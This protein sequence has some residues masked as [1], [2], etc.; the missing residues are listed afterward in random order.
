M[1]RGK[2]SKSK[3]GAQPKKKTGHPVLRWIGY[4][5]FGVVYLY[6]STS[7]WIFQGPFPA[8][9][10]YLI[11]SL[12]ATRHGYLLRP[13]SLYTLPESVIRQNALS[14]QLVTTTKPINDITRENFDTHD[15]SIQ[16]ITDKESLFTAYILLV[17]DPKRIKVVATK[18]LHQH[19]QTVS[20]MVKESGAVAGI[21]GGG[22]VDTNQQGTGAYPQGITMHDGQLLS[23]TGSTTQPQPVIAFTA[24]GQ[25]IAGAYSLPQL[26]GLNT[27][28]AVGFGP[29]L[30]QDGKAVTTESD[31]GRNP[32]TAIGQTADGTVILIVT[33]GREIN[34][35]GATY[36]DIKALMLKYHA[37][38]AANLDGGSSTTMV[39]NG[40]LVNTPWD[41]LGEREV[42]TSIV[43]MPESGKGGQ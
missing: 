26:R 21:N 30:V 1:S 13:L 18:Y 7:L 24:G 34:Q 10:G 2:H 25:M 6:V 4:V 9:K 32:R 3:E 40:K 16:E 27:Q 11:D 36:D 33:N 35:P 17:K 42:S 31:E 37:T 14:E 8:L 5:V 29:V 19:G 41:V 20:D 43:V 39:Y 28:E 23:I 22:F 38:I 12:D 15:G